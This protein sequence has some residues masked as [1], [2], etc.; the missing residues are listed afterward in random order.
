MEPGM[1]GE[2]Y[3]RQF[4]RLGDLAHPKHLTD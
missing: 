2:P 1:E 3:E 4:L